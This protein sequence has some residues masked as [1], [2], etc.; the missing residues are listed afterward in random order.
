MPLT[1]EAALDAQE[2]RR[3]VRPCLQATV[4]IVL[5]VFLDFASHASAQ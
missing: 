1:K 4:V 2:S 3:R 5:R